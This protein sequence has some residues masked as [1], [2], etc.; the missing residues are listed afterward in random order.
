MTD[1]VGRR[2]I[3]RCQCFANA[4]TIRSFDDPSNYLHCGVSIPNWVRYRAKKGQK[5]M[6]DYFPE[7]SE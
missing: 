2:Q 4:C 1:K 3:Y 6:L 5:D 7:V